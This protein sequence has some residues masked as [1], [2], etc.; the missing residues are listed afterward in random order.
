MDSLEGMGFLWLQSKRDS[1][2]ATRDTATRVNANASR[3]SARKGNVLVR[4]GPRKTGDFKRCETY[5]GKYF[6]R[7][8]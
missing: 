7:W 1:P 8:L 5:F 4:I 3:P 6:L 2:A